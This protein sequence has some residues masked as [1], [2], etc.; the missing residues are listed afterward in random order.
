[1]RDGVLEQSAATKL[2]DPSQIVN[3]M[4][5]STIG[6][7]ESVITFKVKAS[8]FNSQEEV[9]PDIFQI[10]ITCKGS[11]ELIFS[12]TEFSMQV[13]KDSIA[14]YPFPDV[15]CQYLFCCQAITFEVRST[16][17]LSTPMAL[18]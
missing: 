14:D 1:M 13:F 10:A 11:S 7:T 12:F 9:H 4:N 17:L 6:I 8:T 2:N 15:S 18:N 5:T 3:I 16:S